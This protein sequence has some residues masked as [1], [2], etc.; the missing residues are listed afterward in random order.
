MDG[1]GIGGNGYMGVGGL[2]LAILRETRTGSYGIGH[3]GITNMA[4]SVLNIG[5]QFIF[6][7]QVHYL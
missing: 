4:G 1:F 6:G 2:T 5:T 7:V 3:L